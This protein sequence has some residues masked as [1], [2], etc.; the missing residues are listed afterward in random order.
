M[1]LLPCFLLLLQA[2]NTNPATKVCDI[3]QCSKFITPGVPARSI[4]NGEVLIPVGDSCS[5]QLTS[6]IGTTRSL[7]FYMDNS[8]AYL[9]YNNN[10]NNNIPHLYTAHTRR[11]HV[12]ILTMF[13]RVIR[14]VYPRLNI[15]H[16]HEHSG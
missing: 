11:K 13:R 15:F 9:R 2:A 1:L 3:D 8:E 14:A 4:T 12:K 6:I 7:Q 10:N 5:I 16:T